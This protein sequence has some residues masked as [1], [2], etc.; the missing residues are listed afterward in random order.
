MY[1]NLKI[2]EARKIL[3]DLK[4]FTMQAKDDL[5]PLDGYASFR[6]E[7]DNSLIKILTDTYFLF[8]H[9]DA[10]D[11][12]VQQLDDYGVNYEIQSLGVNDVGRRHGMVT[13]FSFPELKFD[14]DGSLTT[15]T[16]ELINSNDG[17]Q[18]IMRVFGAYRMKC[19]NGMFI[20]ETLFKEKRKHYGNHYELEP[21][22]EALDN[23]KPN[24]ED[25][26][27]MIEQSRKI[28]IDKSIEKLLI[29]AGFPR[30]MI[31]RLPTMTEKYLSVQQ[32]D[33]KDWK[34]LWSV[35]QALT[36]WISNVV[37]DR[38]LQRAADLQLG[39]YDIVKNAV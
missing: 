25:F 19:S 20:G 18:S 17:N 31:E 5:G 30:L 28:R 14:I 2:E 16:M 21:I 26:G 32:E 1:K 35:Y 34:N 4:V 36:N 6:R 24:F 12:T 22:A 23:L 27:R 29:N 37:V 39:L 11:Q 33:I 8:Q 10:F 38:N 7:R 3:N 15:A 9:I 13:T